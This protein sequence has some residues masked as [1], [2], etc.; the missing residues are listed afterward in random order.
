MKNAVMLGLSALAL[1]ISREDALKKYANLP[2]ALS[3]KC[4]KTCPTYSGKQNRKTLMCKEFKRCKNIKCAEGQ[5]QHPRKLCSCTN[6]KMMEKKINS[7]NT[8]LT[9]CG[10]PPAKWARCGGLVEKCTMYSPYNWNKCKCEKRNYCKKGCPSG[11]A[12]D[13]GHFCKCVDFLDEV[14]PS[15]LLVDSNDGECD[16]NHY[17]NEDADFCV[18]YNWCPKNH[19][20]GAGRT[21][22]QDD[23]DCK[24]DGSGPDPGNNG[25]DNEDEDEEEEEPVT[26]G[27]N[28]P[29]PPGPTEPEQVIDCTEG[30]RWDERLG[31]CIDSGSTPSCKKAG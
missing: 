3:A 5:M 20:C 30:Y 26:P 4:M 1:A 8:L 23:C 28:T 14:I 24:W 17:Y 31:Y 16:E 2:A 25:G 6:K 7:Y 27:P 11:Q 19:N 9:R 22:V 21:G 18:A 29:N 12:L 15:E 13:P 10:G